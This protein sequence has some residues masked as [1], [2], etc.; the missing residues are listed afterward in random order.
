MWKKYRSWLFPLLIILILTPFLSSI[1]LAVERYFYK[2]GEGRV[3]HFVKNPLLDFLYVYALVPG[4][5]LGIL[6]LIT[7]ILSYIFSA[8]KPLR[9]HALFLVLTLAIGSG[10]IIESGFKELWARP[11]PKQVI[12]F[13]GQN[14]FR[15]FYKPNWFLPRTEQMKSFPCGHCAMGFY[16]FAPALIGLRF[17][18]R[19]LFIGSLT[20]AIVL[21]V[22]LSLTRMAQGGHFFSDTIFSALIMWY[23]ALFLDWLIYEERR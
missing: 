22:A 15:P 7:L 3:E 23:T 12:E 19:G 6:S 9:Q 10:I 4:Q 16:F 18:K 13:G 14:E 2:L 17:R 20:L 5:I 11:R 1:D 21:G 8:F